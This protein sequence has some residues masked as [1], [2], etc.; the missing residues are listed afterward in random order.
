MDTKTIAPRAW[1]R[2]LDDL[3]RIYDGAPV[4]LQILR[5]GYGEEEQVVNEPLRGI[6][7]DRTGVLIET[8]HD[9]ENHLAH[10]IPDPIGIRVEQSDEGA[11]RALE[12]ESLDG[13]MTKMRFRFPIIPELA[14]P[15]TD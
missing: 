15:Q 13:T 10:R 5:L 9:P 12:V 7:A 3:S 8:A 6:S 2:E 14:D 4:T 11:I 1:K